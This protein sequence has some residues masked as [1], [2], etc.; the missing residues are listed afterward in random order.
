MKIT[1]V[2]GCGRSAVPPFARPRAS[3]LA[4]LALGEV[5]EASGPRRCRASRLAGRTPH[6]QT[7]NLNLRRR[8]GEDVEIR[9]APEGMSAVDE[10]PGDRAMLSTDH[11]PPIGP[12]YHAV[13]YDACSVRVRPHRRWCARQSHSLRGKSLM[14]VACFCGSRYSVAGDLGACSACGA[15][16]VLG[17]VSDAEES[18]G[19]RGVRAAGCR[20][21]PGRESNP[22]AGGRADAVRRAHRG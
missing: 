5:S 19:A 8:T 20:R 3:A 6:E 16:A 15:Y 21:D 7:L 1:S 9:A 13:R 18:E 10:A 11:P 2:A 17:R 4:A 12:I 22:R 14:D